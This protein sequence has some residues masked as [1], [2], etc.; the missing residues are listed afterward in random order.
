MLEAVRRLQGGRVLVIG[1]IIQDEY[2]RGHTTRINPEA[3]GAFLLDVEEKSYSPGG[4]ANV[5]VN[6][7]MLGGKASLIGVVGMD[8]YGN[9]MSDI[10]K[11]IGVHP[12]I[13]QQK[14]RPTIVKTRLIAEGR[15]IG[16][17]DVEI[18]DDF[19]DDIQ[20]AIVHS[21]KNEMAWADAVIIADY[22]KGVFSK[23]VSHETM[24]IAD[25]LNKFIL[26]DPYPPTIRDWKLYN[27]ATAICPNL[28]EFGQCGKTPE[29]LMNNSGII[30]IA[31]TEGENGVT[32]FQKYA[33]D[34]HFDSEVVEVFDV[35]GCGDTFAAAFALGQIAY[36]S[37]KKSAFVANIAAGIVAGK[38]GTASVFPNELEKSLA[39]K[40][41][42]VSV[43]GMGLM[44][45]NPQ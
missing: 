24:A 1:D 12:A 14:E 9:Q 29:Q 16:R 35:A 8:S 32:L 27:G 38:T 20:K 23:N 2:W 7:A 11:G 4:A 19:P 30:A 40:E 22:A 33:E 17:A 3:P 6:V 39:L 13:I 41:E 37:L 45:E 36:E 18:T 10:L 44:S 43:L 21:I 26:V 5:A 42:A 25:K 31:R 15:Q 34:I 28:R